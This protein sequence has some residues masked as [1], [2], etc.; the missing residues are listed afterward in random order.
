[1][2]N[3]TVFMTRLGDS[4]DVLDQVHAWRQAGES[5]AL[6]TVVGTWGSSP[7]P[8]GSQMAITASGRVTGSVSGGCVESAVM[9]AAMVTLSESRPQLLDYGVSTERAWEVGLACGGQLQVFV[10][11]VE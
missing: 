7:R 10:E 1:M 3:E 2:S 9:A 4:E 6:A 5:V 11:E 8:V